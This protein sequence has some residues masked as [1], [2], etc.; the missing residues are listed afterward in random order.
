M[1]RFYF[2]AA[3]LLY[4]VSMFVAMA[5]T[6]YAQSSELPTRTCADGLELFLPYVAQQ[7]GGIEFVTDINCYGEPMNSSIPESIGL[8]SELTKLM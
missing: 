3:L 1:A 5:P 8:Y 4:I 2:S 6:T 7:V